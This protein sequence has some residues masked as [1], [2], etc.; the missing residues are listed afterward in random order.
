MV[1]TAGALFPLHKRHM[2]RLGDVDIFHARGFGMRRG[3]NLQGTAGEPFE[4]RRRLTIGETAARRAVDFISLL[5]LREFVGIGRQHDGH[6]IET[7]R[8]RA[9]D[10]KRDLDRLEF[11]V[12]RRQRGSGLV[13]LV[14]RGT[15]INRNDSQHRDDR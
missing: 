9:A 3:R 10:D 11:S 5:T 8:R 12:G 7:K 2:H 13:G 1:A 14:D 6:A 15:E 4:L